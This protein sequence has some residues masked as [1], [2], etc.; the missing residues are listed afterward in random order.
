MWFGCENGHRSLWYPR[1]HIGMHDYSTGQ[2]LL[3]RRCITSVIQKTHLTR[4]GRLEGRESFDQQIDFANGN[5]AACATSARGCGPLRPK[6]RG[7]PI[8]AL[9]ISHFLANELEQL[10]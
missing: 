8:A 1:L 10:G 5:P 4:A 2:R 9:S 3:E 6:K 7:S